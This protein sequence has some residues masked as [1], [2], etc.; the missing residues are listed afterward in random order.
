MAALCIAVASGTAAGAQEARAVV[1]VSEILA[2]PHAAPDSTGEWIELQN[3]SNTAVNLRNWIVRSGND[4]PHR[5]RDNLTIQPR[6]YLTL[7]RSTSRSVNGGAPV[8]YSWGADIALANGFDWVVIASPDGATADSA[9]WRRPVR[10]VATGRIPGAPL[11]PDADGDAWIT[12]APAF[13]QGDLGTPGAP[14]VGDRSLAAY[15]NAASVSAAAGQHARYT[16]Q[17]SDLVVRIL[18]VGQGDATLISNGSGIALID[19]GPDAS[20]L[21][22]L[23]DSLGIRDTVVDLVVATHPHADHYL[24]LQ[25]LFDTRRGIRVRRFAENLDTSPNAGLRRLRDSVSA[26]VRRNETMLVDT[27]DPCSS[28]VPTCTFLLAGG[29]RLQLLRPPPH[30]V[31]PNDRSAIVRLLAPDSTALTMWL[32]GDAEH[33]AIDWM[34]HTAGYDTSPGMRAHIVTANHHGSCDGISNELL[35]R[36]TPEWIVMQLAARND[37]GYVHEQTKSLL[38]R[39]GVRW[40]RTDM[41][42]TVTITASGNRRTIVPSRGTANESGP[43]DRH[44]TQRTCR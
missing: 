5:I 30:A 13:G 6:G 20:R 4:R 16:N 42:G 24:G 1:T 19:G 33:S 38:R 7:G 23:L 41:N 25:A 32:A 34:L 18:D 28:G 12:Q 8:A 44:S 9:A 39:R 40:Y 15:R 29:A 35:S 21:G 43:A 31:E 3:H 37:Y 11:E 36:L 22:H 2:N 10:G 27:D 14:N 26:R 17:N